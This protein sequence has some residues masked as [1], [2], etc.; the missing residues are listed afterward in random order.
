MN[1]VQ[2]IVGSFQKTALSQINN[3]ESST[4]TT[5]SADMNWFNT[6]VGRQS[7]APMHAIT[8]LN[9]V[10][11]FCVH[12]FSFGAW[13]LKKATLFQCH[14]LK[15][16]LAKDTF[17]PIIK[18][19]KPIDRRNKKQPKSLKSEQNCWWNHLMALLTCRTCSVHLLKIII[20]Q[21]ASKIIARAAICWKE[22]LT[23]QTVLRST[24][25]CDDACWRHCTK[26]YHQLLN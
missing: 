9:T 12:R 24:F 4:I 15:H 6:C 19:K 2:I 22:N 7:A 20:V 1:N 3:N 11:Q 25:L 16:A 26:S 10:C 14:N 8:G 18:P 17:F 21:I 5:T 13:W 23:L